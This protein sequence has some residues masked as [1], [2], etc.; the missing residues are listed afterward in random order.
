MFKIKKEYKEILASSARL[1][2]EKGLSP[3]L[4]FGDV[5]VMDSETN[6]IYICPRPNEYFKIPNWG[7]TKADNVCVVDIDGNLIEDVGLLP[8]VEMPVHLYIY[9]ARTEVKAIIHSHAI[10]SSAYSI[11][12]KNIPLVI[13][14]QA[15]LLGGEIIC[16][17]YGL[18]GSNTLADNIVKA[19]GKDKR[20]ALMRN[21][22]AVVIGRDI[23]EAFAFSDFLEKAIQSII[24][25][26]ILG[27]VLEISPDNILDD[28]VVNPYL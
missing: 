4:D 8:T 16:A 20:A 22:G 10:W 7:I 15:I 19:L 17:E 11:T 5:S 3:C 26:N 6:Y 2:Y 25:G 9:K 13:S 12:G 14:A 21:H 28:N 1:L 18:V 24:M 23:V 27:K